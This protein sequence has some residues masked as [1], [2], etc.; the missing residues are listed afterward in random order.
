MREPNSPVAIYAMSV[1]A[2]TTSPYPAPF[3]ARIT[4]R[5]K[6]A[7]G[8][9]F[10][11]KDFGVNLTHLAPGAQSALHHRHSAQEEF[12]YILNGTPTLITDAG[13]SELRPGMCAGFVAQGTAHHLINRSDQ[14]V[15]Y[16]EIGTRLAT[17]VVSYPNDDLQAINTGDGRWDF[18]HADGSPYSS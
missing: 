18:V 14:D 11:L 10:L 16:L 2:R 1:A 9:V 6:R 4:G 13:E 15:V 3:A 12:I 8:D 7:L 17:D 5:M